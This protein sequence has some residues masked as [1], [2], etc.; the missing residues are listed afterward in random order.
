MPVF[1]G[2]H[3]FGGPLTEEEM[4]HNWEMYQE[5]CKKHGA[6]AWKVY[7]NLEEGKVFCVTEAKS[8]DDVNAAHNDIERPT[9]ELHEV[10]KLK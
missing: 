8:A 4:K 9:K 7:Y 5:S 6:E 2:I 10:Q 3:D 1:L